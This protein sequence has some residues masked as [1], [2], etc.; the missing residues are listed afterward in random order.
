M[1]RSVT[2]IIIFL[3]HDI[4]FRTPGSGIYDNLRKY[5]LPYPEA[6][7]DIAY[8]RSNPEPFNT[9]AKEFF[10]GVNYR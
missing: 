6:I 7:F 5:N 2:S 3:Y 1:A 9:W 8:F 4:I 10:P